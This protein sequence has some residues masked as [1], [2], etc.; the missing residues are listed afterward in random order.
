MAPQ[1]K[2]KTEREECFERVL[3]RLRQQR[4]QCEEHAVHFLKLGDVENKNKFLQSAEK[5]KHDVD[6]V[7]ALMING[8]A[9]PTFAYQVG[10]R[11]Y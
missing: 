9:P 11:C 2:A 10:H 5:F 1:G 3:E 6:S 4:K 8:E 7:L